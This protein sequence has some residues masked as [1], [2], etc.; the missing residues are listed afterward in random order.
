MEHVNGQGCRKGLTME[1][2]VDGAGKLNE[3]SAEIKSPGLGAA[4]GLGAAFEL[5]FQLN[6]D[7]AARIEAWAHQRL[8][9]DA[10]GDRGRYQITSVYCDTPA[11]DVFHRS[12][13]YRRSKFRLRRYGVS[14]RAFLERKTKRGDRVKKRRS[15]ISAEE[16]ALLANPA[17][18]P[19]TGWVGDWFHQRIHDRKLRPTCC[20]SYHRTAFFGMAGHTPMRLTL[21]R[22]VIGNTNDDWS[23]P[24]VKD[25]HALLP[26]QA[27]LE[28]KFHLHLPGLFHELLALLPGQLA[29]ASKYRRCIELCGLW[30]GPAGGSPVVQVTGPLAAPATLT[31]ASAAEAIR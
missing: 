1:L 3:N 6:L 7:E 15:E 14:H 28:L 29:R 11:L 26:G 25:G 21:D 10:H 13:G 17:A 2:A 31:P 18:P 22:N 27:L 5:K 20:V 19:P 4:D 16:L 24:H 30:V 9:P 23:I 12:P 8:T